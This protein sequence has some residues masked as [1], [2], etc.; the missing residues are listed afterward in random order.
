MD[1]SYSR[2]DKGRISKAGTNY[3][4]GFIPVGSF[5]PSERECFHCDKKTWRWRESVFCLHS[6]EPIGS[7]AV[8][9]SQHLPGERVQIALH[10]QAQSLISE[11]NF[12]LL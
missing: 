7:A 12:M 2:N 8:G 3:S 9:V 10:C 4:S 1:H 11:T 5:D 6:V